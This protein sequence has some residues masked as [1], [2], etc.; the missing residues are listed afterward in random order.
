MEDILLEALEGIYSTE[1]RIDLKAGGLLQLL[2][3]FI[4]LFG[5]RLVTFI[6]VQHR[7]F[8]SIKK[9]NKQKIIIWFCKMLFLLLML[10]NNFTK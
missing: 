10:H 9:T 3:K 2:E 5:K 1:L 6:L 8:P 7:K 4:S